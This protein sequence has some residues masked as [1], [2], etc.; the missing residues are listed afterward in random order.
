[1]G[2]WEGLRKGL[3]LRSCEFWE[4]TLCRVQRRRAWDRTP[5]AHKVS[6][7]GFGRLFTQWTMRC[8]RV[9]NTEKTEETQEGRAP[10][11]AY[12]CLRAWCLSLLCHQDIC[13]RPQPFPRQPP[14]VGPQAYMLVSLLVSLD[15]LENPLNKSPHKWCG[16]GAVALSL[17]A[18]LC[19]WQVPAVP[20]VPTSR[21]PPSLCAPDSVMLALYQLPQNCFSDFCVALAVASVL[22]TLLVLGECCF[23]LILLCLRGYSSSPCLLHESFQPL[24]PLR[25]F[26]G[27]SVSWGCQ[28]K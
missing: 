1:M 21:R 17:S 18:C 22:N 15:L 27:V 14:H 26:A 11:Q 6:S 24:T 13:S 23:L 2:S 10:A 3:L 7:W 12:V 5:Q 9:V 20:S 8:M 19:S 28:N 16:E 4:G 25:Y